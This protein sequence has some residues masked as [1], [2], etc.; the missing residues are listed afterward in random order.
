MIPS[1]LG[2]AKA[3]TQTLQ[4][5]GKELDSRLRGN[6]RAEAAARLIAVI[7]L[8]LALGYLVILG[9]AA[10]SGQWLI[11]PQGR[12]I[13]SDFVNVWAAG[14]LAADGHP[15]LAYDWTVHKSME[16][17]AVGHAFAN[18]YGWHY[19]P[20]FL[21]VASALALVPILPATFLWLA[22]TLPAYLAAIRA[23]LGHRAGYLLALGFPATLWNVTASQNGFLTAALI[24]GTLTMLERQ[25]IVAGVCLGLL[26]YKPHFGLLF[27]IALIA[28]RQWR[29]LIAASATAVAM[30]ALSL[31]VFGTS[32]WLAF[33]AATP[34]MTQAVLSEGLAEFGRLQSVFGF[35]RSVDGSESAAW[36]AQIIVALACA[37][38]TFALWRS[39]VPY[40]L[41]A[42]SLAA[43]ALIAT[44]Y[45]YIYDLVVLAIPAAY[46]LRR[47]IAR[48]VTLID[49][50][51]ASAALLL[52][53][54]YPYC[55]TQVGLAAAAII[56]G[57]L[58]PHLTSGAWP[59]SFGG[60]P[61]RA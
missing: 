46:L 7:G 5:P 9:S 38:T 12:P 29:A 36:T 1:P 18:Y 16:V 19:P 53:L 44:P 22:V 21:F 45:L 55:K 23:I 28:A 33:F 32:P 42:A 59:R 47:A 30:I 11:D 35:V 49:C 52:L 25:P 51:G 3:G 17:R 34:K 60:A 14:R 56:A 27:P 50:L 61:G 40:E 8:T 2:P 37:A 13:A 4:R 48:G 26:T 57:L 20:T 31:I 39:R 15:A 41:K 24:G 54:S 6:D 58:V 10:F 43:L